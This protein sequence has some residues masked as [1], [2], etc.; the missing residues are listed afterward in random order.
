MTADFW[1]PSCGVPL[2][3]AEAAAGRT[4]R[5]G[6][7]GTAFLVVAG[8]PPVLAPADAGAGG[9]APD[10]A[11]ES[12]FGKPPARP[13]GPGAL[14]LILLG[15]A[16]VVFVGVLAVVWFLPGTLFRGNAQG[17]PGQQPP[18]MPGGPGMVGPPGGPGGPPG[19]IPGPP[20]GPPMPGGPGGQTPP[21][22]PL[23]EDKRALAGQWQMEGEK[24]VNVSFT[25][26]GTMTFAPP[27]APALQGP[28]RFR[29]DGSLVLEGKLQ[30]APGPV[31]IG[32]K[33]MQLDKD[34]LTLTDQMD[35]TL[36]FKRVPAPG[37]AEGK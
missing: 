10:L 31:N 29:E 16:V 26:E 5:C 36:K 9:D 35:Q 13:K 37:G 19:G 14:P 28:V 3:P 15:V 4:S 2:N 30:G 24:P 11:D 12:P 25:E 6:R 21:P 27:G 22:T 32:W 17:G 18:G 20:G 1:C 34:E 8:Q 33:K 23:P 7:C